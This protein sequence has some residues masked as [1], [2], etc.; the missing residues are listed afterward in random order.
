MTL[1]LLPFTLQWF[2]FKQDMHPTQGSWD[3]ADKILYG[4]S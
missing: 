3:V 1:A 4:L 2:R